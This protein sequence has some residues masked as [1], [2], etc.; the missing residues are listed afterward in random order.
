[1]A[2]L[3]VVLAI[4]P[5]MRLAKRH[6]RNPAFGIVAC[7]FVALGLAVVGFVVY[8]ITEGFDNPGGRALAAG[9]ITG[10][11]VATVAPLLAWYCR[12]RRPASWQPPEASRRAG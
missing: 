4:I 7:L 6:G 3:A 9:V 5:I 12:P 2:P 10:L 1:M 8:F 11:A